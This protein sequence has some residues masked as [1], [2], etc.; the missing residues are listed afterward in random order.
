MNGMAASVSRAAVFIPVLDIQLPPEFSINELAGLLGQRNTKLIV[1][2]TRGRAYNVK[3]D[4]DRL[5]IEARTAD[6]D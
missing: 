4:L 1:L 2:A 3:S 5:S 6:S